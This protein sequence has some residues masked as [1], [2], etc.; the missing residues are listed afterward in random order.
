M[1]HRASVVAQT[2]I[3]FSKKQ[4]LQLIQEYL[5]SEGLSDSASVLQR[6]ANIAVLNAPSNRSLMHRS[7]NNT[8]N[9]MITPST[10]HRP[11][12]STSSLNR[13]MTSPTASTSV[14]N[15]SLSDCPGTPSSPPTS[16]LKALE[17]SA[18]STPN[19]PIRINRNRGGRHDTPMGTPAS[20]SKNIQRACEPF[21]LP[22]ASEFNQVRGLFQTKMKYPRLITLLLL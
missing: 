19:I 5:A 11:I 3:R 21:S 22:N 10:P 8:P 18:M 6:E 16:S 9:P 1:L 7:V 12:T 2:K 13:G 4:L 14:V 17:S 20:S 15:R